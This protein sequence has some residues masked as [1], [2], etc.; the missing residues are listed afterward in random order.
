MSPL[1]AI[2][3][4]VLDKIIGLILEAVKDELVMPLAERRKVSIR[5]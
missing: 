2:A 5:V 4:Q 1:E 3:M